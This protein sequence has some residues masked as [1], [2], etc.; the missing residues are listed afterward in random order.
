MNTLHPDLQRY[1]AKLRDAIETDLERRRSCRRTGARILQIG[2]PGFAVSLG[3]TLTLVLAGSQAA[4]A[5]WSPSPTP[6]S[7]GQTSSADATCQAQLAAAPPIA[8]GVAAG[9]GWSE[10]STDVRGPF[11]LVT[12]QNGSGSATCLS[13]PSITVVSQDTASGGSVSVSRGVKVSGSGRGLGAVGSVSIL[14]MSSGTIKHATLTHVSSA[15]QDPFSFVEG[16]V[17]E[18]VTGVTLV[19]SDG[20]HVQA[21]TDNGWFLAWWPGSL[22]TTS[23]EI[24]TASGVTTQ[25]L[26]VDTPPMAPP[27]DNTLCPHARGP[28]STVACS[29]GAARGEAGSTTTA[30]SNTGN[31]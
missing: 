14:R 20:E 1:R 19:L 31:S 18:G 6:A 10:V 7:A 13:G 2:V 28:S 11:T 3:L 9:G 23:A 15:G 8:P 21:S 24:A 5:G 25:T 12:Y 30:T 17:D 16:Q 26:T 4:F 29:G 22:D 27:P